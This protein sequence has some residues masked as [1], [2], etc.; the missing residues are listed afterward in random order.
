MGYPCLAIAYNTTVEKE[1]TERRVRAKIDTV[2]DMAEVIPTE[3]RDQSRD[4]QR[5]ILQDPQPIPIHLHAFGANPT[6]FRQNPVAT[7]KLCALSSGS[8]CAAIVLSGNLILRC[9]SFAFFHSVSA[10]RSACT[11]L[12]LIYTISFLPPVRISLS[13]SF[14]PFTLYLISTWLHFSP[15]FGQNSPRHPSSSQWVP[16]RHSWTTSTTS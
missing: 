10:G 11:A 7:Q 1:Y 14:F 6:Q 3:V 5:Y 15:R 16:A 9:Q 2:L 4:P 8:A 13:F 12:S